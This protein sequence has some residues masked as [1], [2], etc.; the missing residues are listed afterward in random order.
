MSGNGALLKVLDFRR[1]PLNLYRR[2]RQECSAGHP[3]ESRS[4]E[5]E[6]RSKRWK[7]CA[8]EIYASGTLSGKFKRRTTGRI[9]WDE[10]K[11]LTSTWAASGSW[12]G[13]VAGPTP[14]STPGAV[15][16]RV[17]IQEATA[18]FLAVREASQIA[19]AT[20]RK[21]RTF[22]RKLQAYAD[23]KGYVCLDQFT[24]ADMDV[25]YA[26]W[27][28]GARA[29]GKALS[30]LRG[31]FVFAVNREWLTKSPV[32]SDL[33][34]PLGANRVVNKAPFTDEELTRLVDT[35]DLIQPIAWN[36]GDKTGI[37]GGED[38]KD[39]MWML[40]YTGLRISDVALFRMDRLKG[41]EV[42]LRARKNGGDVFSWLP[43]WLVHRLER[44]AKEHGLMPFRLGDSL[45]V[46]TVTDLW[47]R[48]LNRVFD[49][50]GKFEERPTPHRFRH[51]FVR[52]LLQRGVP[53]ADVAILIGDDEETV[54]THYAK[55]VS[56][57]QARLT[58]ILKDAFDD[59]P[60][61][62]LVQIP[63]KTGS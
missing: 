12:D 50:A 5:L 31:F 19:Q 28:L 27:K 36:S 14:T 37:W 15:G 3:E 56:E 22:V 2:H 4:G 1:M 63:K 58:S 10:A 18:A 34:P 41:N 30:T 26:G 48:R 29:K 42:F 21:Y 39:F 17:T 49:L 11:A 13:T 59:K 60:R 61:P 55:W 57:R 32:T 46:E 45:R 62:K 51:T 53:V 25:F 9:T 38:V 33:K 23:A 16:S 8:C 44:R 52:I 6:E 7:R 24:R 47:R 43:D 35:C 40:A 20:M 54:Q